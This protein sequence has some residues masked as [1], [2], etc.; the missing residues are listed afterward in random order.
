MLIGGCV[1]WLFSSMLVRAVGRAA[2]YIINECRIQFRDKE[3]WAGTK[4]PNYGRV[5]DIC[6]SAAQ[7][8]LIG[9]ALLSVLSPILVGIVFGPYALG[10]F[11]AGMIVSGVMLG[12]FMANAGGAWDNAKKAIED[13]PRD[14]A[15][16]TGKGSEKHKAAVTG[17]T[18]GDPLKDTAG[19]AINPMLKVMNMVAM[20]TLTSVT[21]AYNMTGFRNPLTPDVA[22]NGM[23]GAVISV[24]IVL[25]V[26]WSIRNSHK[27]SVIKDLETG[28]AAPQEEVGVGAG[29]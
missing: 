20:L 21:L 1:P 26:I 10:G 13:E 15:R 18:V 9:P 5:V 6:T 14:M 16:N 29:K 11:L 25:L 3:I 22:P 12:V 23:I 2:Y 8:E 19:P 24:A 7:S 28:A 17:D 4:K 27:E